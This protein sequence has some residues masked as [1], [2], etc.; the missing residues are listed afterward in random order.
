MRR[1]VRMGWRGSPTFLNPVHPLHLASRF[2]DHLDAVGPLVVDAA[3]T[4]GLGEVVQHGPGGARQVAQVAVLSVHALRHG[5]GAKTTRSYHALVCVP[6]KAGADTHTTL[7]SP[8]H[9]PRLLATAKL[10]VCDTRAIASLS[11]GRQT[12]RLLALVI[13]AA[14]PE[15]TR[16]CSSTPS[17]VQRSHPSRQLL[18]IYITVAGKARVRMRATQ[19]RQWLASQADSRVRV[20]AEWCVVTHATH[21]ITFD[22]RRRLCPQASVS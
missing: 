11:C 1:L 22:I 4:H 15:T 6:H 10:C 18:E 20:V 2:D 14:V 8:P 13:Q 12:V 7:T 19:S 17:L 21:C 5:H 3:S 9:S 16:L